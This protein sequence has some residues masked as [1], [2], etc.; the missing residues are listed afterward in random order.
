[1]SSTSNA[2]CFGIFAEEVESDGTRLEVTLLEAPWR[3]GNTEHASKDRK[4]D[5]YN[6]T[7]DGPE[8]QTWTDFE[9]DCDAVNQAASSKLNDSGYNACQRV[10]GRNPP[11]MKDAILECDGADLG[12]VSRQQARELTQ[13]R[14]MT[15]TQTPC[16]PSKLGLGSHT[17][18]ETSLATCSE[19]NTTRANY[20]LDNLFGSGDVERMQ[21]G[22]QQMFF[23]TRAL[24]PATRWPQFGLPPAVP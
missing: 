14:M 24:S 16:P 19:R 9:D 6:M 2:A 7:Q 23:G 20:M 8:A 5:N 1:M 22:N 17:P 10:F 4:E 18:V 15:N 3:N 13:E 21:P 11:L 12:V